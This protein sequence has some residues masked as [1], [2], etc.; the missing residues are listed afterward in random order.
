MRI[1]STA[2]MLAMLAAVPACAAGLAPCAGPVEAKNVHVIRVEKN[3]DLVLADGRAVRL[4]GLLLPA[5]SRDHAPDYL[6]GQA[7]AALGDLASNRDVT[8][9]VFVPKEDRYGRLRA[10]V[11]FPQTKD[12]PW[13]QVA[14]LRRGFARVSIAP[15]RRECASEL[16]A[17]EAY[18]RKKRFGIWGTGFYDVLTPDQLDGTV[19]TFQI[20][21]GKVLST[22]IKN[23]RAFLDF[24][25][26]WRRDF[27][28]TI[29]PDDMRRFRDT[30]VDPRT[31]EGL[32]IRV[33]GFVD[34]FGGPEIEVASPEAVEVVQTPL[35]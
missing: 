7:I 4:E 5:G 30:G 21:E 32:T 24:G 33:R 12:E 13:L 27:K 2:I 11:F 10:Q 35:Q 18:A 19:G 15:D 22:G 25:R 28:V 14:M 26:D 1:V 9:A 34:E 8:L 16:Y 29:A 6:A 23:G 3:G 31:Y 17:A 20:V